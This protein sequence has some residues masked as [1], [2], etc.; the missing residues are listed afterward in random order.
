MNNEEYQNNE[1]VEEKQSL[2]IDDFDFTMIADFFRRLKRQGPGGDWE[3]RLATSLIPSFK[4]KIRIA[5]MGCGMGS[6][7]FVLADEYD[8]EID[9]VDLLP[10]MVEGIRQETERRGLQDV[11]HA[12]KASMDNLPFTP[13]SHDLLWAEGSIFVMGY[14]R[15][16]RYWHQFLKPGGYVAVTDCSWLGSRR[17]ND[18]QWIADNIPE[19]DTIAHK[20]EQMEAAGYEPYAHFVLPETCWTTNYYQPM[21]PIMKQFLMDHPTSGAQAFVDRLKE[22]IAY[23]EANKDTYGYVFYIGRKV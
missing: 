12:V 17:P 15:G 10:E 16:L 4:R 23:Y 2:T 5:D 7:T 6:Q 8:A 20:L 19:I 22:E 13:E 14:E 3:T 11:V 18:I 1:N 21:L 9:A